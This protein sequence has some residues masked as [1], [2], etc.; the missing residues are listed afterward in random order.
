VKRT[1]NLSALILMALAGHGHAASGVTCSGYFSD[2]SQEPIRMAI[3]IE[4]NGDTA[5]TSYASGTAKVIEGQ[6][7]PN[8]ISFK[9]ETWDGWLNR[10]SGDAELELTPPGPTVGVRL[11]CKPAKALF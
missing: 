4:I 10:Y 1:T 11:K 9:A 7:N 5:T 8:S 6:P 3:T 2:P